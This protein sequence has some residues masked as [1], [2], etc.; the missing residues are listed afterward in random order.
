MANN[1]QIP[2]PIEYARKVFGVCL[3]M[4]PLVAYNYASKNH[5]RMKEFFVAAH[6]AGLIVSVFCVAFYR[7]F[8]SAIVSAFIS[9]MDMVS[10]GTEFLQSRC[11]ATPFMFLSFHIVHFM[12]AVDRGKVSFQM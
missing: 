1:C 5:K 7:V 10:F 6:L 3:E 12:Q 11:F 9:D 4:A 2:T 8:A